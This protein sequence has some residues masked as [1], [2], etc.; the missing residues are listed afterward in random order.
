MNVLAL[1]SDTRVLVGSVEHFV[2]ILLSI[3]FTIALVIFAK[4]A[5]VSTQHILFKVLG[6]TVFGGLLLYHLPHLLSGNYNYKT[7]L[8]LYLCSFMAL[9][10][11][12]FTQTRRFWMFEVLVFWVIAG[13][14]QGIVTPDI[15]VGFPSLDYFRYWIVHLGLVVVIV[16]AISV[17][18]MHPNFKSLIK[19]FIAL[20]LYFVF[21]LLLNYILG[22]NYMYLNYKPE[23]ASIVDYLGDW[24]WYILS[25]QALVIP[26]F[27]L[28]YLPFYLH[29]TQEQS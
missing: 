22:S 2:P 5:S 15:A 10:V 9:V 24:P 26:A 7:D 12:F 18:K 1:L 28:V 8:P 4:K 21:A 25:M 14:I 17:F 6:W 27:L 20:Q 23:S 29:N 13:T 3:V 19:S 11:P 16:Y